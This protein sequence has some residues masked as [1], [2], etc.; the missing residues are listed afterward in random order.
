MRCARIVRAC[1]IRYMSMRRGV[2]MRQAESAS[3]ESLP[4]TEPSRRPVQIFAA[5]F[6]AAAIVYSFQ[7]GTD[8]LGA[9]EAYSA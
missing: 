2:E 8:A 7:L 3:I 6:V 1:E 5:I 9:S 4:Q